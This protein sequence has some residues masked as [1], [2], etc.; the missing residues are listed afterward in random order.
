MKILLMVVGL[1]ITLGSSAAEYYDMPMLRRMGCSCEDNAQ[2][3]AFLTR[4]NNKVAR[5]L[6]SDYKIQAGM[7]QANSSVMRSVLGSSSGLDVAV[8]VTSRKNYERPVVLINF[9]GF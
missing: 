5:V 6:A 9:G 8:W 7:I 1:F 2:R 3:D 4:V